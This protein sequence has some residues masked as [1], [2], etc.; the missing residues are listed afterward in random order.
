MTTG[1]C[2]RC[3]VSSLDKTY[4]VSNYYFVGGAYGKSSERNIMME[5]KQNGPIVTSFEP[6]YDFMLYNGG[7]YHSAKLE[8]WVFDEETRPEW[9]K[10]DHSVLL[11]GWGEENGEKYWEL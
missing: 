4:K 1:Q 5:L 2:G 10:V 3:D 11:Y 7:I 8:D 9:E 6:A